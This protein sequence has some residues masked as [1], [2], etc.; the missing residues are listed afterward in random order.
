GR[1][2]EWIY[3][4]DST[5]QRLLLRF[6]G[7]ELSGPLPLGAQ[8]HF[9]VLIAAK[10]QA[11]QQRNDL[12]SAKEDYLRLLHWHQ[13]VAAQNP[14]S[15]ADAAP[16]RVYVALGKNAELRNRLDEAEDWY[17]RAAK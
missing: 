2:S 12:V 4:L 3:L 7:S 16:A 6:G 1:Q 8:G 17:Q 13:H 15:S 11:A 5:L 10:A 9:Q 14:G